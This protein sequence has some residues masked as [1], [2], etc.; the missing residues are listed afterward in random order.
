MNRPP[1]P[2]GDARPGEPRMI[3]PGL[4]ELTPAGPRIVVG[5]QRDGS[6]VFPLS[7]AAEGECKP[8]LLGPTGTLWSWTVQR[9]RPKSPPYVDAG[10]EFAPFVVG[11]VEFPEGIIIEGRIVARAD[12]DVLR[13]GMAMEVTVIPLCADA[14]GAPLHLFA[15]RPAEAGA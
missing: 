7:Q 15:F 14:N 3:A 11:Y 1:E 10:G 6:L 8:A 12:R 13:V 9:F 4:V 5:R 2:L